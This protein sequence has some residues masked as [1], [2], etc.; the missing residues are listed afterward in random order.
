MPCL[1]LIIFSAWFLSFSLKK[2]I[3]HELRIIL[4]IY[5]DV[6]VK[7]EATSN[8]T[9]HNPRPRHYS[10]IL[11]SFT[12][13][14]NAPTIRCIQYSW[15]SLKFIKKCNTVKSNFPYCF[16]QLMHI[17]L[18]YLL[19]GGSLLPFTS[20]ADVYNIRHFFFVHLKYSVIQIF[21]GRPDNFSC[22]FLF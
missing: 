8:I 3:V 22:I 14:M 6:I 19:K 7:S 13:S 5:L 11:F 21:P 20:L 9:V 18:R 4:Q 17:Y 10:I 2:D 15:K 1:A 12:I 16:T